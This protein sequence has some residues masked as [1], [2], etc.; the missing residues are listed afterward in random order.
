MALSTIFHYVVV[1]VLSGC[2]AV[3]YCS[4]Q[5]ARACFCLIGVGILLVLD[6]LK[7]NVKIVNTYHDC[8]FITTPPPGAAASGC[9]E[10]G[11]NGKSE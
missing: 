10:T 6:E 11:A 8:E 3:M 7:R 2:T 5:V 4:G 9:S 1:A